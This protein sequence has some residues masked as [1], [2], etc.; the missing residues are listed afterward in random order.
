MD[1]KT[2]QRIIAIIQARMGSKRLPG[3]VLADIQGEPMI[4]RVVE[5]TQRA[6]TLDGVVVATTTE[7]TDDAVAAL[8]ASRDYDFTRGHATDVLARYLQ[9]AQVH[10]ADI[11]VRITG[12]CPLIDPGVI[13][14]TVNAFIDSDPPVDYASNRIVRSY[15][16]GMDVE[17]VSLASL[18]RADQEATE[19]YHREHVTPYFYETA[20]RFEV[21][22][23]ESDTA[24]GELRWT[25]DTEEDLRFVREI[26]A[27]LKDNPDFGWRD[28][29]ELLE[30]EPGLIEINAHVRQKTYRQT[31]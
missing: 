18:Q 29:L 17:V 15:P 25:V 4:V 19:A 14:R 20:G 26:Y 23:V 9:A 21:L 11:V 13:D 7:K 12:D 1:H 28:V 3:K 31:E 8:C 30:A 5:R 2:K 10:Q 22:S 16:I 27:R 6:Q 24:Y